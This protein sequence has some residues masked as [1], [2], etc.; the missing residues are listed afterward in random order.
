MS[1]ISVVALAAALALAGAAEKRANP[2]AAV[3][4]DF[5]DRVDAYM[6]LRKTAEG[7]L[8]KLKPKE[9][10]AEVMQHERQLAAA[11]RAARPVAKQGE[12]FTP[13]IAAE[14]RRLITETMR[15]PEGA[16]I[17]QS[18]RSAEPVRAPIEI[19]A[20]YPS[21]VPLQSTP[22]TLLLNLPKLPQELRYQIV[23][24]DLILQDEPANL[25]V[26]FIPAALP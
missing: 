4:K 19:N 16:R 10:A 21:K 13:P 22:P 1:S 7:G 5:S 20:A 8:P 18:L 23:G 12:V 17:R 24:R 2:D 25:V 15:G 11:I 6:K 9:S 3:L 14:F 26:D